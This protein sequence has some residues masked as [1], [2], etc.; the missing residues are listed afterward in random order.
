MT[1]LLD[2]KMMTHHSVMTLSL[3]I[4]ILKID[5]FCVFSSDIDY[6]IRTLGVVTHPV[7]WQWPGG[8]EGMPGSTRSPGCYPVKSLVLLC[9]GN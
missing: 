3:R 4:K 6:N 7:T 1:Q 8:P 5:K 9:T 2:Q